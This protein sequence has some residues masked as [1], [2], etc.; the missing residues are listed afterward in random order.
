MPG[1]AVAQPAD[2]RRAAGEAEREQDDVLGDPV[3][4]DEAAVEPAA[5]AAGEDLR[6]DLE[7]VEAVVAVDRCPERDVDAR[8]RDRRLDGLAALAAERGRRG[9]GRRAAGWPDWPGCSPK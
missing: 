5:L 9:S 2:D 4:A 3:L 7:R 6:R 1:R 8:E